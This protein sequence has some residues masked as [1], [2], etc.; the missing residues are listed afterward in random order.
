MRR[1][2]GEGLAVVLAGM[3]GHVAPNPSRAVCWKFR[4]FAA[5]FNSVFDPLWH[6]VRPLYDRF[7]VLR[8]AAL[9]V[10]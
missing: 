3:T 10:F 7:W 8:P 9:G 5:D 6:N 1:G 4:D 2:S